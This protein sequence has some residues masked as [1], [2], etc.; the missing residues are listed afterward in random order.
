MPM[1]LASTITAVGSSLAARSSVTTS[2]PQLNAVLV[3]GFMASTFA[4]LFCFM[5]RE[6]QRHMLGYAIASSAMA[7]F[8]FLVTG[9][10]PLGLTQIACAIIAWRRWREAGHPSSGR[11]GPPHAAQYAQASHAH[12]LFEPGEPY[13]EAWTN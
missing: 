13:D 2:P 12:R 9:A 4:M 10:W 5:Q 7:V 6:S 1:L 8:G 11:I 3:F